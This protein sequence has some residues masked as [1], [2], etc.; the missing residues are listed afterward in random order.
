MAVWVCGLLSGVMSADT[1][2][3]KSGIE[4]GRFT[5]PGNWTSDGTH[6][7]P[8]PGDIVKFTTAGVKVDN[9]A[10]FN[11][12]GAG[13]TIDCD[14]F[15]TADMNVD[16]ENGL[17]LLFA[18]TGDGPVTKT[19]QGQMMLKK[20]WTTSG[21]VAVNDGWLCL[22]SGNEWSGTY[23]L[24][25]SK[26]VLDRTGGKNP[27]LFLFNK[28][29]QLT[30]EVE[31]VGASFSSV[32]NASIAGSNDAG[33]F[34]GKV[35][36]STDF[37][38]AGGHCNSAPGDAARR[39]WYGCD[40]DAPGQT[41]YL[42]SCVSW[43]TF[44][45]LSGTVNCSIDCASASKANKIVHFEFNGKGT[46]QNA[47]LTLGA[48]SNIFFRGAVWIGTNVLVKAGKGL[49]LNGNGN[50]SPLASLRL[51]KNA[52]VTIEPGVRVAVSEFIT[53]GF[54]RMPGL[55]T[56]SNL[57]G[58]IGGSGSLLVLGPC[59]L[60]TGGEYGNWDEPSNWS[61][62]QVPPTGTCAV[63][64]NPVTNLASKAPVDISNGGLMLYCDYKTASFGTENFWNYDY[65]KGIRLFM[66]VTGSGELVKDGGGQVLVE[67]K[68][69]STGG[70]RVKDGILGTVP[71]RTATLNEAFGNNK[72]TIDRRFGG[73]PQVAIYNRYVQRNVENDIEILGA[74]ST[75]PVASLLETND[76]RAFGGTVTSDN[77]F[78]IASGHCNSSAGQPVV[79]RGWYFIDV[80]AP[81]RTMYL[82]SCASWG[83]YLYYKGRINCSIDGANGQYASQIKL[84]EFEGTGTSID[85]D[86][87]LASS[88]VFL[89]AATWAGTNVTLGAKKTLLLQGENNLSDKATLRLGAG[90]KLGIASGVKVSVA[91]CY[92]N[93]TKLNP[94]VYSSANLPPALSDH[95]IGEGK[96]RV[97][98]SG[99][100]ITLK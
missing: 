34:M 93:G 90:S 39:I 5:D 85:A 96:L 42:D 89:S 52:R 38:I 61:P 63:F 19:G 44:I 78:A 13:L 68:I 60:W 28:G 17:Q 79:N 58:V 16:R 53:D 92:A 64:Q 31:I 40:F 18:L 6:T 15:T 50:L 48:T 36:S 29:V 49:F 95:W 2:T 69:Q 11:V 83:T 98:N 20:P 23:P 8:Q 33:T 56:S 97:G 30:N 71:S 9:D 54:A 51:E 32:P 59:S 57:P 21:T 25:T 94:G 4:T 67:T 37:T 26:V 100:F 7:S 45:N 91:A 74:G 84:F 99:L 65:N 70:I 75:P 46:E 27:Q 88:N 76:G 22:R 41:L 62:A 3:W 14:F 81:G 87:V 1:L 73:T 66:T 47:D 55:Y 80:D 86:L 72:I 43:S 24:G 10:S 82:D 12:T 77:D 35:S